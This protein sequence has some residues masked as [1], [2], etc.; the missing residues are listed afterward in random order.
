MKLYG[1]T[2]LFLGSSVTYGSAAGGV[3]FADL[4]AESC[5]IVCIKEAV[6]G[7]TLA[8]INKNSY[9]SRLKKVCTD[10]KVDLFICQL[11]TNDAAKTIPLQ[12][13]EDAIR[14]ILQYA[15]DTFACPILFYTGT[16]FESEAYEATIHLL[17]DLQK[18][19]D[20]YI[21]DLF[22]DKTMQGISP[23]LYKKYMHDPVHPTFVGYK[24][25][26]TPQFIAFC[27]EKI[28]D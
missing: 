12:K 9:V 26:W 23:D 7:T 6:S 24:E 5:G 17:Y 18:E 11:S 22:N 27:E 14:F 28:P 1:K 25:W 4:M 15:E 2:V 13:T 8:D 16:Y 3:S 19:Y 10:T 21:L 20:F